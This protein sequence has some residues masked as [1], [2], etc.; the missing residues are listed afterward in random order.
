MYMTYRLSRDKCLRFNSRCLHGRRVWN[1]PDIKFIIIRF[2]E[3]KKT[4]SFLNWQRVDKYIAKINQSLPFDQ[5]IEKWNSK[6]GHP[7]TSGSWIWSQE[8]HFFT[9]IIVKSTA[10][11]NRMRYNLPI[12]V[13]RTLAYLPL[14]LITAVVARTI[15]LKFQWLLSVNQMITLESLHSAA[16]S[17]SS[18][19]WKNWW[20]NCV[21]VVLW[22]DGCSSQFR[23]KF[24]FELLTHFNQN[25]ALQLHYNE[26]HHG[27][28]PMD[29]VGGTI[30]RFVYKL[31]KSRHININTA[32]DSSPVAVT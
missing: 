19:S 28:G 25:I 20:A 15:W 1:L 11:S 2:R 26:A 16:L 12:L 31:V 24:I 29:G 7:T 13:S 22:S 3:E 4:I 23:S 32:E 30:K 10:A 17:P 14:A 21:R 8:R 5:A 9:L 6:Q 27:K 18:T